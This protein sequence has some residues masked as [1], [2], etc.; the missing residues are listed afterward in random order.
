T[1]V[2][3]DNGSLLPP[4]R[5]LAAAGP[6]DPVPYRRFERAPGESGGDGD[7]TGD[8]DHGA[9]IAVYR[10]DDTGARSSTFHGRDVFAPVAALVHDHP[11]AEL[12]DRGLLTPLAD[13]VS[14][15]FPEPT[16]ADDRATGEVLVVDDFGNLIT[17]VPG[18][19]LRG[20]ERVGVRPA[21]AATGRD[22]PDT[23]RVVPA[24][25]TFEAVEP[26]E[27][28]ATVGSHGNVELDVNRGRGDERFGLT[29]GDGVTL[30]VDP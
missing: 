11:L 9:E 25:E 28:L 22:A 21:G 13:P 8:G 27:A 2:G 15:S 14:L 7:D 24:V 23:E 29:A 16:V 30:V 17:N 1:L 4:A 20:V 26:G 18:H 12:R 6:P 3:P 19:A 5:R 10:V